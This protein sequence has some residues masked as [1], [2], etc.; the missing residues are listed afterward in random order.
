MPDPR[1][2]FG[3][4]MADLGRAATPPPWSEIKARRVRRTRSVLRRSGIAAVAVVALGAVGA[5]GLTVPGH[6]GDPGG[7]ATPLLTTSAAPSSLI[8]EP[9]V[10]ADSVGFSVT[11]RVYA[12]LHTCVSGCDD[13]SGSV[14][15]TL[16]RSTDTGRSWARRSI[17]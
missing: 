9:A 11:G 12:L 6:H 2:D 4:L 13:L 16:W 1:E 15:A 5:V 3:G 7:D 8:R 10:V 14:E 17:V